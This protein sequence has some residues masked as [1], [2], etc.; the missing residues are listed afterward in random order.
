MNKM[1][2]RYWV[3]GGIATLIIFIA[4]LTIFYLA[5][6]INVVN[7]TVQ[8]LIAPCWD[9]LHFYL[10]GSNDFLRIQ[11]FLIVIIVS[12]IILF[13]IGSMIGWFYGKNKNNG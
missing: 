8:C 4:F 7:Y 11:Q 1:N 6:L 3:R 12:T 10:F 13:S 2:K 5:G 9:E